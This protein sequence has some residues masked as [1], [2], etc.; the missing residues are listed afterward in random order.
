MKRFLKL[1]PLLALTLFMLVSCSDG[2]SSAGKDNDETEKPTEPMVLAD[3]ADISEYKI[4]RPDKCSDELRAAASDLKIRLEEITGAKIA[5]GTDF[6]GDGGKE[7]LFGETKRAISK[8]AAENLKY[9]SSYI[10]KKSGDKI[11]ICGGS[12]E[13]TATA[14]DFWL[15]NMVQGT[16]ICI[17]KSEDGYSYDPNIIIEKLMIDGINISEYSIFCDEEELKDEAKALKQLLIDYSDIHPEI[18]DNLYTT[19]NQIRLSMSK[20]LTL[21]S[22]KLEDGHVNIGYSYLNLSYGSEK[23]KEALDSADGKEFDMNSSINS[24]ETLSCPYTKEELLKVLEKVYNSDGVI[25]GE[26]TP[27]ALAGTVT[28]TINDFKN[29]TGQDLALIGI[30]LRQANLY[31]IG[32]KG[33]NR[34]IADLMGFASRGGIITASAH[35]SNPHHG[36]PNVYD[37]RGYLGK[38]DV[39]AELVTKGTAINESFTQELSSIAD[40]F[41]KLEEKGIPVI[42][43]PLHETNGSWFWFCMV[44]KFEDG[45]FYKISEESFRNLWI[46]IY[47]YMTKERGLT[48]LI[49]AFSPNIGEEK[50]SMVAPLYGYPGDEYV[51]IVGFDWY[52]DGDYNRINTTPTYNDLLSTGKILC[53]TEFG[54]NSALKATGDQKQSD[55]FSCRDVIKYL[56]KMQD[57]GKKMAYMLAWAPPIHIAG[58]GYGDEFMNSAI[59][60]N[61]EE[62]NKI[63]EEVRSSK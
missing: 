54:P 33:V 2:G 7:I 13:S 14:A 44:Q 45:S 43:R 27:V 39:W 23:L 25:I 30:D 26:Q 55:V 40:L 4:I 35:F 15:T 58:L 12:D 59:T 1:F 62:V 42:W 28:H 56:E 36:D 31:K 16:H 50:E 17:P 52:T 22:F 48:N 49:W 53:I 20:D 38:D 5:I 61:L 10:I 41:E 47:D 6:S 32:E 11:V 29:A 63:F 37:P 34:V 51:D 19:A 8:T 60:L 57:E 21:S 46:Y 18:T 9:Y 3:I 24:S